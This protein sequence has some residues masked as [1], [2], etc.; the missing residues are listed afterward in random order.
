MAL[1]VVALLAGCGSGTPMLNSFDVERGIAQ[2]VLVQRHVH[3]IVS[4]PP[5]VPR[6]QGVTFTCT[7]SLQAGRYSVLVVESDAHGHVRWATS[8]PLVI[9]NTVRV[10]RSI[11]D[12]VKA[13]RG[14]DSRVKC[15][16]QVLQKSGVVFTC[17]ATVAARQYPFKVTEVDGRGHVRYVGE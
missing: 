14:L 16:T 13:Q 5:R 6:Q 11:A 4:C 12:S 17:Q 10:E 15:P 9:L 3:T 1:P 8:A 2:S 7:V